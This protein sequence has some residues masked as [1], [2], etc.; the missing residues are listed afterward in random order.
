M[1]IE[2][3]GSRRLRLSL[4]SVPVELWLYFDPGHDPRAIWINSETGDVLAEVPVVRD[5]P[6]VSDQVR[7]RSAGT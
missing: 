3:F 1:Y 6:C 2:T 5:G 4:S 7:H